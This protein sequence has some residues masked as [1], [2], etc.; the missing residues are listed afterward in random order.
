MSPAALFA[1]L[2]LVLGAML[3]FLGSTG[4]SAQTTTSYASPTDGT[5]NNATTCTAPLVRT[6]TVGTSF[7]VS[8]V[9]LGVYVTHTWRGDLR[10]TLQSPDGTR[11]QLVD[12]D[13]ANT[14][15]DN[16][17]VRL[18]DAAAQLVNTDSATGNH[19]TGTPPPFANTFRPNAPLAAF[20]GVNSQ[21][22][23]RL[24]ICD[25][26]PT[27]D[28]G[29][30]RHAELYLTSAPANFADLS[31]SK[32]VNNPGPASGTN[33]TYTLQARSSASSTNTAT[34]VQVTDLLPPGAAYVSHSGPGSYNPATGIWQVGTLAPGGLAT[35]TITATVNASAGAVIVNNAEITASSQADSDSVPGNGAIGEDDFASVGFTVSGARVAGTPPALACTA[36]SQIFDWDVRSWTAGSTVNSYGFSTLG[37]IGFNL[38]NPGTWL[39]N[40]TFGGQS[41]ALQN[42]M[43]G[44]LATPQFSLMELVDLPNRSAV[45]TTTI[46]LPRS[47][48]AAQFSVFDVDFG[49][50]QFADR[51][52]VTGQYRGANVNPVLTNGIV[53]YVVGNAAYGDGVS[54]NTS[55]D[56]NLVVTFQQPVDTIIIEYG[57]HAGAPVDPGQQGVALH[58]IQVCMPTTALSA[59]K[60]STVFSDPVNGATN[61][62]AIPGSVIDYAITVS[63]TGIVAT[64][65][66]QVS[67][68]DQ[69]P[70]QTK[71]CLAD[72]APGSGP[73]LF[74]NT[75]GTSGLAYSFAGLANAG[76]S[77][78][79]SSDGGVSYNYTPVADADGCDAGITHFRVNPAGAFNEAATI[80]LRARFMVR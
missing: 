19:A 80:T 13:T 56:G 34:G 27:A 14:S 52:V 60:T 6:F 51:I 23:W 41:P 72:L 59:T 61:A 8:D 4:L 47:V 77:L 57:N 1:R 49:A 20:N 11:V 39:S 50:N 26:F 30:F 73:V 32:T 74:Q 10:I 5:I 28:N 42:G 3:A 46:N 66:G 9:D 48:M 40:A 76:D 16:F 22:T 54:G 55:A 45:V 79:F 70:P 2:W 7:T 18:D 71:F 38:A 43:T 53:N 63:N 64:D 24:E 78:S 75:A 29:N 69:V 36:G 58:D 65:S 21:G 67:I 33:I 37:Q 31:L 62:K 15:G 17:N 12:G 68:V 25:L 35:L 44:G